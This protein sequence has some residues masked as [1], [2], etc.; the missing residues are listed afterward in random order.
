MQRQALA[1]Q[2]NQERE[3][4]AAVSAFGRA[5]VQADVSVLQRLLTEN[6][7]HVNGRSGSVLNRDQWLKWVASRRAEL[8]SGDRELKDVISNAE[9]RPTVMYLDWGKYD[10][11]DTSEAF[12]TGRSNGQLAEF[13]SAN[14]YNP[15]G[16]EVNEGFGWYSW[17][18]R[19]DKI[20]AAFFPLKKTKK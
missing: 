3:V 7:L 20:L 16:G 15:V 4:R 11:R 13:L 2:T 17:R 8:D 10:Y 19:T 5:F 6:Y 12:D 14:G 1:Q 18:H 9:Q